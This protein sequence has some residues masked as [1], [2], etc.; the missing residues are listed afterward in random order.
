[1]TVTLAV[2]TLPSLV[3][4][5]VV[6]PTATALT[7]PFAETLATVES[8]DDQLTARPAS[9]VPF[10]SRVVADNWTVPP[11]VTLDEPGETETEATG[12]GAGALTVMVE[13]AVLPSLVAVICA[14]P[15]AT[16]VTRPDELTLAISELLE[17]QVMTLPARTLLFASRVV[18]DNCD[19]APIC[20][21]ALAGETATDATGIG[22]GTVTVNVAAPSFPS[23]DALIEAVPAA[24]AETSPV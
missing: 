24:I 15:A 14:L 23:A 21:V 16:A 10:A 17:D 20:S 22:G 6:L 12:M 5:T 9:V 7:K 18:A 1:V 2:P 4:V 19:V 11:I 13:E 8:A 3:A